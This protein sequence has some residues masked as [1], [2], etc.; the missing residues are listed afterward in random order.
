[1]DLNY[2]PICNVLFKPSASELPR[3]VVAADR[4]GSAHT[5]RS[6]FTARGKVLYF[7]EAGLLVFVT[8]K[9]PVLT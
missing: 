5:G 8:Q 1:M 6:T 7:S 9:P 4:P 2:S 3:G